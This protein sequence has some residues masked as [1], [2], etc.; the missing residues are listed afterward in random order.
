MSIDRRHFIAGVALASFG[1]ASPLRAGEKP[2][3]FLAGATGRNGSVILEHLLGLPGAPFAV[4]AMS[5][6]PE[7][8]R[9]RFPSARWVEGDVTKPDSLAAAMAGGVD[10]I[11]SAVAS[12]TAEG[13]NRP[14]AVDAQG[15]RNLIAAGRDA[16]VRRFVIITSSVSGQADHPLNRRLG[17]VLIHKAAAEQAL[18]ESGIEYVVVGPA[19][20]TDEPPGQRR[21]ILIPREQYRPGM[22]I[23][24]ADTARVVHRALIEP[25]AANRT[26]T[27]AYGE[28]AADERW[29]QSFAS[30][31]AR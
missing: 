15:T 27:V 16:G 30:L 17:D 28:G 20:M 19:G 26:F 29:T 23:G 6:Q 9:E 24:R 11:I 3:V 22:T 31:P 1:A 14:E 2:V 4:L 18:Y 8:A 21:I 25:Q 12:S 5:R 7:Q 10:F 13:P